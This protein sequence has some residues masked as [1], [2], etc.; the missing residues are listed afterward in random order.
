MLHRSKE[1]S[2]LRV[3]L[4]SLGGWLHLGKTSLEIRRRKTAFE[5]GVNM[6][7]TAEGYWNGKSEEEIGCVIK[8]V[9]LRHLDFIISTKLHLGT[10][11]GP[12][13]GGL[14]RKQI[15]EDM[16]ESR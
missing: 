10:R 3:P 2:G 6:F 7:N 1:P 13:N 4:F 16:Q 15:F 11:R 8:E 5:N 12:N 9:S 14:S